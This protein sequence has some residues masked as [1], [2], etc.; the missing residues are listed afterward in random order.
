MNKLKKLRLKSKEERRFKAGHPWVFSNELQESPKA[1]GLGELVELCD[2][3]GAFLAFGFG[4]PNSL[5]SFRELT[6]EQNSK[7]IVDGVLSSSLFVEK[8]ERALAFRKSWFKI[9][10]SFRMIYGEADGLSGLIV[11]RFVGQNEV[12]YVVQPHASG[13]DQHLNLI[14]E[15]LIQVSERLEDKNPL[16]I[17]RKDAGSREKEGLTKEAPEVTTLAGE[18]LANSALE[19]LNRFSIQ[20]QGEKR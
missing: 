15:A 7:H 2:A 20:V 16:L 6:R 8:F 12:V 18:A 3:G 13:M 1:L 10:E 19:A 11:D 5:I 9:T 14:R 17:I 4:N